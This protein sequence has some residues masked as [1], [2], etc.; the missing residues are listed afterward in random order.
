VLNQ[1]SIPY[2]SKLKTFFEN[3]DKNKLFIILLS[4][5]VVFAALVRFYKLDQ[6]PMGYNLDE[7]G[8]AYD[9]W[10]LANWRVNRNMMHLPV[11]LPNTGGGQ[12][13]LYAYLSAGLIFIFGMSKFIIRTP[14]V[15]FGLMTIIFASL[16]T[17]EALGKKAGLISAFM[18]AIMPYFIMAS[19]LGFDCNLFLGMSTLSIYLTIVAIKKQ[20]F[21]F[22][23]LAG[24]SWGVTLYTY[25]LSYIAIPI[26]ITLTIIYLLII[27]KI[28]WRQTL[29]F[30]LAI[31]ALAWPLIILIIINHFDL[32]PVYSRFFYIPKLTIWRAGELSGV[33]FFERLIDLPK[34]LFIIPDQ[35]TEAF[36]TSHGTMYNFTPIFIITGTI[37]FCIQGFKSLRKKKFSTNV[38]LTFWVIAM[39]VLVFTLDDIMNYRLN[40]FYFVLAYGLVFILTWLANKFLK[41]WQNLFYIFVVIIFL[42]SFSS[43]A[44]SYFVKQPLAGFPSLHFGD[45]F[46]EPLSYLDDWLND[47]G[48]SSS[49]FQIYLDEKYIYYYLGAL[50]PPQEVDLTK[51]QMREVNYQN[52]HFEWLPENNTEGLPYVPSKINTEDI[53][54]IKNNRSS[55]IEKLINYGF[56]PIYQNL[57]YT[58]YLD[59][60]N[61]LPIPGQQN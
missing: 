55:Y 11:Y 57:R 61:F 1:K 14:A 51:D 36:I 42:F 53:F 24:L 26:F 31:L 15:I 60:H 8:M 52:F 6:L 5:I 9:S 47:R 27:K 34:T 41:H 18:I 16:I 48:Y 23:I 54:I 40:A 7:A 46:S 35:D 22:W 10:A 38:L 58:I 4:I 59:E 49:D 3:I 37:M 20:K 17:K 29:V 28:N 12:S 19:R 21:P 33:N 44:H 50:T 30:G 39:L 13:V 56:T 2:F 25:I 32:P 45:T 43:F